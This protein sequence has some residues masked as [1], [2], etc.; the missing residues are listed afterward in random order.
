MELAHLDDVHR[1]LI[2]KKNK[3]IFFH[4]FT[5]LAISDGL[6]ISKLNKQIFTSEFESDWVAYSF[7]FVPH[8]S[9]KLRKWLL[10]WNKKFKF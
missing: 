5:K 10:L 4:N 1:F 9:K 7:G 6:M 3:I 8:Q 2:Y